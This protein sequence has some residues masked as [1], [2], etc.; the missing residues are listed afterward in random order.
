MCIF[1]SV[2]PATS[3]VFPT[4]ANFQAI[5]GSQAILLIATLAVLVPLVCREFD[6]SVGANLG[7]CAVMSASAME[8]GSSLGVA[9]AISVGIG[10]G[11]GVI[12]GLLVAVARVN[13][14]IVTL[15]TTLLLQGAAQAKTEGR[16]ITS[17]ISPDL[18][19]FGS[20]TTFG[21]PRVLFA[22]LFV[23][24]AVYFVL[25]HTPFGRRIYMIGANPNAARLVGARNERLLLASFAIA[26]L[27]A[28]IGGILFVGQL[29]SADPSA[30][31]L[32][33]L[34]A[35]AAGFLGA[36]AISPGR[37]NVWGSV[38]AITF[39]AVLNGGLNLVGAASYVSQLVNGA[40]LIV[41]VSL[42]VLLGRRRDPEARTLSGI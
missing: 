19:E 18:V 1:F 41:G 16:S 26:G 23:A 3:D 28:G 5:A 37:F 17:G 14:V 9:I 32:L 13:G 10:L 34:P 6:L 11:V 40:A 30:G 33:T 35:L 8:G 21:F 36:A 31:D 29:G 38:V 24:L 20:G 42:A 22:A 39:L 15:G 4:P 2:L 12:N 27:L 25:G 7:L